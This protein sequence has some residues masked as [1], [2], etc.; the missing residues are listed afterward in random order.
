MLKNHSLGKLKDLVSEMLDGKKFEEKI[1][2]NADTWQKHIYVSETTNLA[3]FFQHITVMFLKLLIAHHGW[4]Y[5]WQLEGLKRKVTTRGAL[6]VLSTTVNAC[7]Y[8]PERVHGS[9]TDLQ[10]RLTE[11][12]PKFFL[13]E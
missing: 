7:Q 8:L 9:L 3:I 4:E 13:E 5:A 11:V 10:E 1:S 2:K 6:T 12:K